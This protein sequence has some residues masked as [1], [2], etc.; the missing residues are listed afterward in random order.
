MLPHLEAL[1][2]Y[3][4]SCYA[5]IWPAILLSADSIFCYPAKTKIRPSLC[6]MCALFRPSEKKC[7]RNSLFY[8]SLQCVSLSFLSFSEKRVDR[9]PLDNLNIIHGSYEIRSGTSIIVYTCDEGYIRYGSE[10]LYCIASSWNSLPPKCI[11][12]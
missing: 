9:C 6:V 12:K 3:I 5:E 2:F 1:T 7:F 4:Q 11:S 10:K 8:Y